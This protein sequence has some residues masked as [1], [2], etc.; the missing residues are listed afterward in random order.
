M[1]KQEK[2]N[3]N[4]KRQKNFTLDD[5]KAK[6][7][8]KVNIIFID[9][10]EELDTAIQ[11]LKFCPPIIGVDIETRGLDP[12]QHE[13][14]MF[15]FGDLHRQFV[16]DTRSVDITE[17]IDYIIQDDITIVGQNLKFEYK[18]IYHKFKKR[19]LNVR[20]TMLQEIVL[21]NGYMLRNSLK[22][23]GRRYLGYEADKTIRMRFLTIDDNPFNKQEIMYGAY[24]VV[25]PLLIDAK[26]QDKLKDKDMELLVSLEHEYLKVLGDME[27]KGLYIDRNKWWDLYEKNLPIFINKQKELDKFVID[28]KYYAF[29]ATQIDMFNADTACTISW[30][31]SKQ[32]IELFK[33]LEICPEAMSKSTGKMTYT[34]DAKVMKAS[35][36]T[37]N[38]D[39]KQEYKDLIALYLSMKEYEQRCTTFGSQFLDKHVNPVTGRLHT[40]MNQ[41]ISTGRSS[42][43]DPNLQNIPAG[44]EYRSCFTAPDKY[45]KI[46]NADFSGQE[47]IVLVNKSL[48]PDLIAFYE[49]KH[50]D[51]HSFIA[52]KIFPELNGLTLEEI[53]ASH[54]GLRQIAKAAGFAINYGGNGY[55][56][57][58][59]LG[60]SQEEGDK[61]YDAYFKAFPG[62]RAYF[63]KEISDTLARGYILINEVTNRR[64]NL[65]DYKQMKSYEKKPD[66]RRDYWRLRGKIGRLALNAPIQGTAGDITKN[67]AVRFRKWILNNKLEDQVFITNVIHDEINVE[68][69]ILISTR[70][71]KALTKCMEDAGK[72][73][74]KTVPLLADAQIKDYWT[75]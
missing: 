70:V 11:W 16:I 41:I 71:A 31:S 39:I 38:K 40:N 53:K 32:V 13:M 48:D 54:A 75:H 1:G 19:L 20:D 58:K 51:M 4:V 60:I 49:A 24:D 59:N 67:S 56:I 43:R 9:E 23:L 30:T 27:Y 42:S 3:F 33:V 52:S 72:I 5:V 8:V 7:D 22:E 15:Q 29:I 64:L 46:V 44:P 14:I 73:W 6:T 36:N 68:C 45:H 69:P 74:C 2:M 35:L 47:N 61:V 12:H 63:D 34:V 28:N 65:I 17:V 25:L 55:T 50:S 66:K 57:S 37:M 21:Y 18:F 26:Q 10:Q 62:L